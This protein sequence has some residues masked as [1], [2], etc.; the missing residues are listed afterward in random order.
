MVTLSY[1]D[2]WYKQAPFYHKSIG[3]LFFVL[4]IIR[5]LVRWRGAEVLPAAGLQRWERLAAAWGHRS[6]YVGML[7]VPLLGYGISTADGR[8]IEVFSWFTI[9][10][11]PFAWARQ[12][13]VM[14]LLHKWGAY[15]LVT[16]ALGHAAAAIH[17]GRRVWRRMFT[18]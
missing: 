1:Y 7:L 6:L 15:A 5:L 16:L 14:G 10:A 4:L 18:F 17:H 13:D 8:G 12:E 11:L 3:V 2:P 9:P